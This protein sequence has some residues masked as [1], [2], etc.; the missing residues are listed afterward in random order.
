MLKQSTL[1]TI[2]LLPIIA[3]FLVIIFHLNFLV[4]S[5][6][7]FAPP[8]LYLLSKQQKQISKIIIF[9]SLISLPLTFILDYLITK[10]L[11]WYI[12]KSIFP[13]RLFHQVALEQFVWGFLYT[14]L[15][16]SFYEYF[17]D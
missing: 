14:V 13:I 7:Y 8:A 2:I 16:I 1:I 3:S 15:V 17:L 9:S 6:L 10:D 4:S 12:V 5:I 11:G